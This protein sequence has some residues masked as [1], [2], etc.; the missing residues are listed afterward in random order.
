MVDCLFGVDFWAF[1]SVFTMDICGQIEKTSVYGLLS[2]SLVD[3][4]LIIG[5]KLYTART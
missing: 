3:I 1:G 5:T 2:V 4:T